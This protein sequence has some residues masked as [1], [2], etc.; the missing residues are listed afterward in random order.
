MNIQTGLTYQLLISESAFVDVRWIERSIRLRNGVTE[1][2]K[3]K[4]NINPSIFFHT[5]KYQI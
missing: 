2:E 1:Q 4:K 5:R 3:L